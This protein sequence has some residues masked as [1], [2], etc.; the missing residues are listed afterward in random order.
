MMEIKYFLK[1]FYPPIFSPPP[2]SSSRTMTTP[3]VTVALYEKKSFACPA[4]A[5]LARQDCKRLL[6]HLFDHTMHSNLVLESTAHEK[7]A[8]LIHQLDRAVIRQEQQLAAA[9]APLVQQRTLWLVP[10]AKSKVRMQRQW[11]HVLGLEKSRTWPLS[12]QSLAQEEESAPRHCTLLTITEFL[13]ELCAASSSNDGDGLEL[14]LFQHAILEDVEV[15]LY[16]AAQQV[17]G[18]QQVLKACATVIWASGEQVTGD[19]EDW[20][21]GCSGTRRLVKLEGISDTRV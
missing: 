8:A 18:L 2:P 7:T 14:S 19:M 17:T 15:L 11:A 6:D 5:S 20:L 10:N 4:G 16:E 3:P 1:I 21:F 13:D 12:F 9:R